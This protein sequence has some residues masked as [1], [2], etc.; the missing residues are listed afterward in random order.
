MNLAPQAWVA[1]NTQ[2]HRERYAVED[3]ERQEFHAYCPSIRKQVRHARRAREV[4]RPLFP[5]Y[6]FVQVD[7]ELQQ[8]RPILSTFGV[9]SVVRC[10]DR[11]SFVE[12]SF[13]ESLRAR[14]IDGA[15]AKPEGALH[16]GQRVN[17]AGGPV[18][19]LVEISERDRLTVL[20]NLLNQP[21][22]VK[23]HTQQISPV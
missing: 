6:V 4:V 9:R 20:M 5:G 23:V 7:P 3:L 19:G 1:V 12:D 11:L 2:P 21:T 13:V 16:V 18:D 8:W 10:G 22:K 15:I 17:I 14:E